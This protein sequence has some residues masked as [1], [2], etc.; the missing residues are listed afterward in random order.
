MPEE[1]STSRRY[2]QLCHSFNA[3]AEGWPKLQPQEAMHALS[4]TKGS[5]TM[6][7]LHMALRRDPA[8][9]ETLHRLML[10]DLP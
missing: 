2:A 4:L 1:N 7:I 10:E 8:L 9:D 3:P 6:V 5:I